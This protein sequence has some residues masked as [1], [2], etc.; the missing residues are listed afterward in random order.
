M[1]ISYQSLAIL[2]FPEYRV[3]T[4]GSVWSR[5]SRRWTPLKLRPSKDGY[6]SVTLKNWISSK[7]FAVHTLV[8]TAFRGP[9]PLGLICRHFPDGDRTNNQLSN[10]QWGTWQENAAD[11]VV[12]GTATIGENNGNSKL[13]REQ[14]E[15]IKTLKGKFSHRALAKMFNVGKSTIGDILQGK[16]WTK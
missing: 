16:K 4:D 6:L 12:H 9:C 5:H 13:T 11:K 1:T 2:G 15:K 3:G 10:L 14:V 7:W 8:L